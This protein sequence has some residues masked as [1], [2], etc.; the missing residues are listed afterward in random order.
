V[1]STP[2]TD[3]TNKPSISK[4]F[5][6]TGFLLIAIVATG[7]LLGSPTAPQTPFAN[8]TR[9]DVPANLPEDDWTGGPRECDVLQG[10]STSCIFPD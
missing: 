10:I 6:P 1:E 5:A 7:Y 2:E 3:M 9:L 8:H 4:R